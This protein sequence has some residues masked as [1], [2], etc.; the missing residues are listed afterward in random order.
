MILMIVLLVLSFLAW[1]FTKKSQT[2]KK[3]QL[4][5]VVPMMIAIIALAAGAVEKKIIENGNYVEKNENGEGDRELKLYVE[6]PD[7]MEAEE[8]DLSIP[9]RNLAKEEVYDL[10]SKARDE[11]QRTICAEN[12]S[13]KQIC[14]SLNLPA[15]FC[16]GRVKAS[17]EITPDGCIDEE[18]NILWD[19][20]EKNTEIQVGY[21]SDSCRTVNRKEPPW[22]RAR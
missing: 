8:Y 19:N 17:Y 15:K 13:L 3:Y 1:R 21:N 5:C 9:E 6:S 10:L 2:M 4:V 14:K 16:D 22:A 12:T 20:I 7:V 11:L 18:G